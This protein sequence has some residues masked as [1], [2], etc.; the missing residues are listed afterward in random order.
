M[1]ETFADFHV[2]R[3][4][5]RLRGDLVTRTALHVGGG[6]A[7]VVEA[8]DLPVMRDAEGWP[9]IPG[10]SLKGVLRS[11]VE[12]LVRAAEDREAGLWACDPFVESGEHAA[13]GSQLGDSDKRGPDEDDLSAH[14]TVCSLFG[15]RVLASHVRFSDAVMLGRDGRP[16]VE[17]RDGVAIDRDLRV[18]SRGQK[19]DFEV[20]APGTRFDL[21]VFVENPDDR[22]LGLLA[23]GFDQL[24]EGLSALGGF[25]SR[26]LGRVDLVWKDV[27]RFTADQILAGKDH[28]VL[29]GEAREAEFDRWRAALAASMRGGN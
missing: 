14:C 18:A 5:L 20:V 16:P 28:E 7:G 6:G 2:L 12:A 26:G 1:A 21:E 10:S 3:G 25:T 24:D 8:T 29:E 15:S 9:F 22:L 23:I 27:S 4:R 19:Y 13:C 11:T 17:V